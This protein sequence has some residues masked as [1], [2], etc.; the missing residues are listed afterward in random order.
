LLHKNKQKKLKINKYIT[1]YKPP[2]YVSIIPERL[3]HGEHKEGTKD[4]R[5]YQKLDFDT[6]FFN[7]R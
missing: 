3:N 5:L 7:A 1:F 4:T 2:V 6:A